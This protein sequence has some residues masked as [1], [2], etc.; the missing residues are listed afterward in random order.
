MISYEFYKVLHVFSVIGFIA[1]L[2]LQLNLD[3]KDKKMAIFSG[4]LTLLVL[5]GGMGLLA[6]LNISHSHGWPLWAKLKLT[7]WLLL[8]IGVPVINKRF[9]QF[10]R[11]ASRVLFLMVLLA[12]ILA[13]YKL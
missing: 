12:V 10:K 9:P 8:G 7:I 3:H 2:Y 5:T 13:V 11:M 1:L 6:R 4:I